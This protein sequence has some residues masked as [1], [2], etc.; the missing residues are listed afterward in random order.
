[1]RST[2]RILATAAAAALALTA[3]S[4]SDGPAAEAP[5]GDRS[6][7]TIAAV[8]GWDDVV[9]S[10]VL[11][12]S[13]LN[14]QGY[15]VS[16]EY[17]DIATAFVGLSA[18]DYDLYLGSWLPQTHGEY[19]EE[20]GD[21]L[22]EIGVW[23]DQA[24]NTI[25]VNAD[26]PVD[27][28]AELAEN[29]AAFDNRIVGIEAGAGITRLTEEAVIPGYGLED[30]EFVTSSTPA[31]LAELQGAIDAGENIAV[32]LWQPHWIYS[33][34]DLK[35]LEDPDSALGEAESITMFSRTGFADDAPVARGWLADFE[36]DLHQLAGL[37]SALQPGA[38]TGEYDDLIAGWIDENRAWVDGLT[39]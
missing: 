38:E 20:Y 21:D 10:S 23:N 28:L 33:E 27:S 30:M 32:T 8:S 5:N 34:L 3:C 31:M 6:E 19:I 36:M 7:I 13:V 35:N 4:S 37:Q 1:M 15:D 2:A 17:V 11:W 9:A 16:V 14:E 22:E 26:A 12:Q 39:A 25:A 18:G 29:A 24:Q